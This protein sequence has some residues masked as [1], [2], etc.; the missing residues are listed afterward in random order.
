[1]SCARAAAFSASPTFS[2]ANT[3]PLSKLTAAAL[4]LLL[5]PDYLPPAASHH[6]HSSGTQAVRRVTSTHCDI[7][8]AKRAWSAATSRALFKVAACASWCRDLVWKPPLS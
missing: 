5:L 8:R 2:T 6:S 4:L 3:E 7:S 1:M